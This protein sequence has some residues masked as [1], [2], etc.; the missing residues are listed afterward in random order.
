MLWLEGALSPPAA[1]A[2]LPMSG[3]Y[4]LNSANLAA[5]AASVLLSAGGGGLLALFSSVLLSE[6]RFLLLTGKGAIFIFPSGA[7]IRSN[8]GRW[9]GWLGE[10][11]S[12]A[13]FSGSALADG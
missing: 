11:A 13:R 3:M 4:F 5:A 2:L 10:W 9:A 8:R 12:S 1:S 7:W 6:G